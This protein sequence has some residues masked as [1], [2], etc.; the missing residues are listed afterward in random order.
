MATR[1]VILGGG[2]GGVV[3]ANAL[4]G[5]LPREHEIVVVERKPTFHLGATKPWV[6]LGLKTEAEVSRPVDALA[7]RGISVV[8]G[9]VVKIDPARREVAT[10]KETLSAD[11]L[12]L[13]LGVDLNMEAVPGLAKAAETFYTMDGAIR[14]GK[15]LREFKGGDVA[16]LVA[17][18]PIKCPPAPYEMAMLLDHEF[19]A[20]GVR[21]KTRMALVTVEPAPTPTAGPEVSGRLREELARREIAYHPGKRVK[22]VEGERRAVVFEDGGEARYDLL[23][24]VPPHEAPRVVREAGLAKAGGWIPVD[25][26]TLRTA[27]ER[28]WA[29]GDVT[30]VPLP[31]RYKPD[32]P[33]VLPKAAVFAD[34]HGRVVAAQIAAHAL[35]KEPG[36]AFDGRGFCFVETGNRHAM[37]GEGAFFELP[38]PKVAARVP[39]LAQFE[40]KEAW[41]S[42]FLKRNF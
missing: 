39:D 30:S 32:A 1:T 19:R 3:T 12:V 5:L 38:H 27:H 2:V 15:V 36:A 22:A 8:R 4:R 14:L 42:G 23:I 20:R 28:V 6:M 34:A 18:V 33:L 21:E 26:A 24:A 7:V 25:P 13:A 37:G 40:E 31:G 17:R 9:E 41:A 16:I 29:I 10:A 35:G 11:Y